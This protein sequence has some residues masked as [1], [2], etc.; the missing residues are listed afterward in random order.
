MAAVVLHRVQYIHE[1]ALN[2]CGFMTSIGKGKK[3]VEAE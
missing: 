3:D 2:V 1:L